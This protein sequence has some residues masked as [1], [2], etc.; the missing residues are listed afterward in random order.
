M[1]TVC[2]FELNSPPE[3]RLPERV[4]IPVDLSAA[5]VQA[6]GEKLKIYSSVGPA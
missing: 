1:R 4:Y 2:Q 5:T 6:A 3:D